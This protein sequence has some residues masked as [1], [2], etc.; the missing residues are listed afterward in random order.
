[1]TN[2][3]LISEASYKFFW[4]N[5]QNF[6]GSELLKIEKFLLPENRASTI[7]P[8]Y[9][10]NSKAKLIFLS[11][12]LKKNSANVV[13]KFTA[14]DAL[15]EIVETDF[16]MV[17]IYR[18]ITY[19]ADSFEYFKSPNEGFCGS[20]EVEVFSEFKPIYTYPAISLVYQNLI[21]CSIVHSCVRAYN[22]SESNDDYALNFPQTGFDIVTSEDNR[23]YI[24]FFGG[25]KSSYDLTFILISENIEKKVSI[26]VENTKQYQM[27]IIYVENLFVDIQYLKKIKLTIFH[28]L[29][30]FPRFYAGVVKVGFVPTLTHS[31]FDTTEKNFAIDYPFLNLRSHNENPENNFDCAFMIPIYRNAD[32]N[33]RIVTYGQNLTH[34]SDVFL[35][36][37]SDIGH[38]LIQKKLD[39]QESNKLNKLSY[40]DI[41][42][43][44][45]SNK[46]SKEERYSLHFG[47]VNNRE[48]PFPKRF[49]LALNVSRKGEELGSNICFAPLVMTESTLTKPFNRRW[50]PLGGEE[51]FIASIHNAS[52]LRNDLGISTNIAC[53]FVNIN[54]NVLVREMYLTANSSLYLDTNGDEE[55]RSFF[56]G[57]TGWC[58]VTSM[59]YH[60]DSYYF[61]T[62]GRLIGGDHAY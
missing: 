55:L 21:G 38:I 35:T 43:L 53:E 42:E 57:A 4:N 47:F 28:N 61:A 25:R 44:L 48:K 33:T 31:F 29:D 7:F 15:G 20:I 56:C 34:D 58:L 17:L 5:L 16:M 62:S 26:R 6:I 45:K 24:C 8:I 49:K 51:C 60:C 22:R 23:N 9:L 11:Y 3:H 1:M 2:S 50:F 37:Y 36:A 54:G 14:R 40:I 27:H 19:N 30:V 18:S 12:W 10:N 13:I 52:I 32:Y 39:P 59:S 46:L 41:S